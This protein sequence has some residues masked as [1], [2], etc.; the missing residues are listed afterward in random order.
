[1]IPIIPSSPSFNGPT[2]PGDDFQIT[3][4]GNFTS[5]SVS[6]SNVVE[7][8]ANLFQLSYPL[9]LDFNQSVHR[10]MSKSKRQTWSNRES[11]N[12]NLARLFAGSLSSAQQA[13]LTVQQASIVGSFLFNV[14]N[15]FQSALEDVNSVIQNFLDDYQLTDISETND[16]NDSISALNSAHDTSLQGKAAS[17]QATAA[18]NSAQTVANDASAAYAVAYDAYQTAETNFY[19]ATDAFDI[20]AA[21]YLAAQSVYGVAQQDYAN[22]Q[23]AYNLAVSNYQQGLISQTDYDQAVIDWQAAQQSFSNSTAAFNNVQTTYTQAQTTLNAAQDVYSQA[24]IDLNNALQVSNDANAALSAAQNAMNQASAAYSQA[25]DDEISALHAYQAASVHYRAYVG[26]RSNDIPLVLGII[27]LYNTAVNSVNAQIATFNELIQSNFISNATLAEFNSFLPDPPIPTHPPLDL[28]PTPIP[29]S[30]VSNTIT[31]VLTGPDDLIGVLSPVTSG[32]LELYRITVMRLRRMSAFTSFMRYKKAGKDPTKVDSYQ[33][34]HHNMAN[35]LSGAR[36]A[37][38]SGPGAGV[39]LTAMT[40][41]YEPL[42]AGLLT[43][44]VGSFQD[45][46]YIN[47]DRILDQL[48]SFTEELL[49]KI[50]LFAASPVLQ[51]IEDRQLSFNLGHLEDHSPAIEALVGLGF[52]QQVLFMTSKDNVPAIQKVIEDVLRKAFP[53]ATPDQMSQMATAFTAAVSF[54]LLRTA[55]SQIAQVLNLPQLPA[56]LLAHLDHGPSQATIEA[57]LVSSLLDVIGNSVS[58]EQLQKALVQFLVANNILPVSNANTLINSIVHKAIA[59]LLKDLSPNPTPNLVDAKFNR[60]LLVA[61]IN[62]SIVSDSAVDI[63]KK[64]IKIVKKLLAETDDVV[65]QGDVLKLQD[66]LKHLKKAIVEQLVQEGTLSYNDAQSVADSIQAAVLSMQPGVAFNASQFITVFQNEIAKLTSVPLDEQAIKAIATHVFDAIQQVSSVDSSQPQP[67]GI[68]QPQLY[69]LIKDIL[70]TQ[71]I[72]E[73]EAIKAAQSAVQLIANQNSTSQNVFSD[74]SLQQL[75]N[76]LLAEL[77]QNGIKREDAIKVAN[78]ADILIKAEIK[79]VD[80][81]EANIK[82]NINSSSIAQSIAIADHRIDQIIAEEAVRDAILELSQTPSSTPQ[83]SPPPTQAPGGDTTN[84]TEPPTSPSSSTSS[85]ASHSLRDLRDTIVD[86]LVTRGVDRETALSAVTESIF[87]SLSTSPIFHPIS[88]TQLETQIASRIFSILS[89][90]VGLNHIEDHMHE[91][92]SAIVGKERINGHY[93][94]ILHQLD[95]QLK[96]IKGVGNEQFSDFID[97]NLRMMF[98]PFLSSYIQNQIRQSPAY[99][100]VHSVLTSIQGTLPTNYQHTL[101][102][103]V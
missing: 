12:R 47:N 73:D 55:L 98:R 41:I 88:L 49:S 1:M 23:S 26:H 10:G 13:V 31:P 39:D 96:I 81:L 5:D 30:L 35:R 50:G 3:G 58:V 83:P 61:L 87:G 79:G 100:L 74:A 45:S 86:Q 20:A 103:I 82:A 24:G 32:N 11:I 89:P 94:S 99:N 84:R 60:A 4:G 72:P 21:D 64:V 101:D 67:V 70:I 7:S 78:Y 93:E 69:D 40:L 90:E 56:Q 2:D 15:Q 17:T 85:L 57:G 43:Q 62:D 9:L 19:A 34:D 38:P 37:G 36:G 28:L 75:K 66:I 42:L 6:G 102:I 8:S 77:V 16:L 44:L 22:A 92:V 46:F 63:T 71:K 18:R 29:V 53:E 54:S 76:N 51:K 48:R 27:D 91:F 33:T 14:Y 25:L 52:L 59:A 80:D 95:E 97:D 68:N 65:G